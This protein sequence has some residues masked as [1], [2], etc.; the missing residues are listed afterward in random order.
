MISIFVN[1]I[2]S[3]LRQN[4]FVWLGCISIACWW[5]I[6]HFENPTTPI[7]INADNLTYLPILG[8]ISM[9]F[10]VLP[11]IVFVCSQQFR[12]LRWQEKL[13]SV[14][15]ALMLT[16]IVFRPYAYLHA[17]I[18]FF[19]FTFIAFVCDK[20]RQW[21]IPPIFYFACLIYV[22]W[23]SISML[24]TNSTE[25]TTYFNRI[26][27]LASYSLTFSLINLS[28]KNYHLLI[29][30]FW[31]VV[32]IASLLTIASG[33]YEAQR[34]NIEFTEFIQFQKTPIQN[35][36]VYQFLYAW[37][38]V[39][40]PSYNALWLVAGLTSGFFLTYKNIL[41]R[42]ELLYS[43]TLI[44]FVVIITQSR[45][46]LIM[47][48]VIAIVGTMYLLRHYKFALLSIMTMLC[49]LGF[50]I[51][52]THAHI[53]PAFYTDPA[54]MSLL[55]IAT[56]YLQVNPWKGCGLGG[57]T[58]EHIES[59][60]GYEFKSW[61]PQYKT[62]TMYP[63]NQFLGDWMQAGI[64]GL[65][66]L[67][68][69][70]IGGFYDSFKQYNFIG[71]VYLLAICLFMLIEMPFHYLGGSTIIAFFLCFILGHHDSQSHDTSLN[72]SA[73]DSSKKMR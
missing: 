37:S 28:K 18:I 40:H 12:L 14:G 50:Y 7:F 17:Q 55:Q 66:V 54:R 22:I 27:P 6:C 65:L 4:V 1:K 56:D 69:I 26:I 34:M 61:W 45:I 63:H 15:I 49:I 33:I 39:G 71:F 11:F 48:I 29:L 67:I 62:T 2:I 43:C 8:V 36:P 23:L 51:C 59:V 64:I 31:R 72:T 42:M 5:V 60:I 68:G 13:Q 3:W 10:L 25:A 52:F 53:I 20:N 46:G 44:L 73:C 30:L 32:C 58:Y 19:L 41:T 35:T 47:W 16:T 9:C 57:M 38:G 24:W 70:I 21:K